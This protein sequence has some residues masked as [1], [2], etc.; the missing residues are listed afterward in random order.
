MKLKYNI[1][2]I[3][4][5]I[6]L[7]Y[8]C[9][10]YRHNIYNFFKNLIVMRNKKLISKI[11]FIIISII[12]VSIIVLAFLGKKDRLGYLS[13]FKINTYHTLELNGLNTNETKQLFTVDNMLDETS[14]NNFIFTN[15]SI[16]N[17]SYDFRIKY[18]SKIFRN[19]DIYGVYPNLNNLPQYIKSIKMYDNTGTPFG[20]LT[21]A[22]EL[23][24]DD[25]I[26]TQYY[27]MLNFNIFYYIAII[28]IIS[29][30][31]IGFYLLKEYWKYKKTLDIKIIYL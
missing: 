20:Y 6:L 10:I 19:S 4:I 8:I 1:I 26:D 5:A 31:C 14:I 2:L 30:L 21:S 7:I 12:I 22:K 17:Y 27:L 3:Y 28:F 16:T 9:L 11:C 18:Y 24:Y 13:E 25:K 15:T 23:K 29:L